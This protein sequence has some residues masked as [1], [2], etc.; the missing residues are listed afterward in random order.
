MTN[1]STLNRRHFIKNLTLGAS[2][3]VLVPMLNRIA[4]GA[5]G[6][7]PPLRFLF[8]LEG[9]SVPPR[10]VCPDGIPFVEREERTKFVEH[11]LHDTTLPTALKPIED[12]RDQLTI[13][14]GLSGRMCSGG[15]SSDHGA[16]GAYHANSG[17]SILAPTIDAVLGQAY[18]GI[19]ENLVLGISSD[20]RKAVDFNCSAAA[21]GR[22]LATLLHPDIAYTRLF[23]SI[24][25]GRAKSSFRA[26][27][28]VLDY[29]KDDIKRARRELGSV[30]KAKMDAYLS[31]YEG[32]DATSKRLVE[33]RET[34]ESV[35][36]ERTDKFSSTVE[37]D[38]LDAHFELATAAL[39]GGMTNCATI[40]S[41]VGFPNF[42]ITFT[43]LGIQTGKHPIGHG[44]YIE[45]DRTAWE[46]SQK[47][48]AFHFQ[49][50]NRTMKK[51]ASM[52]EGD[53]TM[54]DRTVI[55]YLSDGA[56]THHSRCF[57]WPF[58]VLGN[59]NGRLRAGRYLQYP[60][61]GTDGHRTIN[62]LYHTF[63]H[64][65]G[66]PRDEFGSLDPNLDESMHRGPLEE[67]YV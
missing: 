21:R 19:F 40:A 8:V 25:E 7:T 34:L 16:L 36:P 39:I 10:Q 2:A 67:F 51:L 32:L 37:T 31:A 15:H 62:A 56:E 22:S 13:V 63:L 14:Q 60:D 59:A 5:D 66:L 27:A 24:A 41:G 38:R 29:I 23:G 20:V 17:R 45:D 1:Q 46:Q 65:A 35:V 47:I 57:E 26:R 28:N 11:S 49:L 52:P 53:G 18:P 6:D 12:F 4:M 64:A 42:N 33:S 30:E 55:V 3:P 43:G 50:I 58:V 48:R 54:L 61:Y 9:N 44:L